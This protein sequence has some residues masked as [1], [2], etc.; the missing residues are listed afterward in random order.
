MYG[1]TVKAGA[2]IT[3][4]D[5]YGYFRFDDVM[6]VKEAAVVTV[7]YSGYFNAIKTYAVT[8]GKPAFF[9][10]KLLPKTIAGT[11]ESVAGGTV[12]L[13]NG[14]SITFPANAVKDI[15]TGLLYNGTVKVAAHWIDPTSPELN[16][17]MP[18]DLRGINTQGAMKL[19]TTF[20]MVAVEITGSGGESLKIIEGKKAEMSIPIPASILAIAPATI[21]LW[22][23]NEQKGLWKEEGIATKTGDKYI[24]EVSHFSFWNCDIPANFVQFSCTILDNNNNPVPFARVKISEISNPVNARWGFTNSAGFVSGFVPSNTSLKFELYNSGVCSAIIYSQNFNT[25]NIAYSAGNII[26]PSTTTS[27]ATISGTVTNC[28]NNPV[29]NGYVM[30]TVNNEFTRYYLNTQGAYNFS[31]FI[32]SNPAPLII[33]AVDLDSLKESSVVNYNLS[34]GVNAMPPMQTCNLFRSFYDGK[35]TLN[36]IHNRPN[37]NFPFTNVSMELITTGV[38][39]VAFY[40]PAAG[41]IGHPFAIDGNNT[42][43]WYGPAIAPAIKFN[44]FTNE[45]TDAYNLAGATPISLYNGPL[46]THNYFDSVNRKVYVAWQYNNNIERAFFDTLTYI[47]PR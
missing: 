36:G 21:P 45:I 11:I 2:G 42:L 35:F 4:T 37:Y 39:D 10:I 19:L 46:P 20:G 9:R 6:V 1:A 22:Y 17:I 33:Y 7:E 15:A 8:E 29:T 27:M 5:K 44:R 38:N 40:W 31:V 28:A 16:N 13:P 26:M 32:C 18:G 34:P 25:V 14:L 43:S 12:S 3:K 47:G 41:S 30:I 23:F 24:G